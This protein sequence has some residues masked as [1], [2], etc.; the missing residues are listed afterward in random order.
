MEP[1]P[2]A[3]TTGGETPLRRTHPISP[4]IQVARS[5]PAFIFFV[6]FAVSRGASLPT[7]G[8]A[9]VV[10][11]VGVLAAGT[12]FLQWQRRVFWFDADGDLRV[13]SGVVRRNERRVQLSRLQGV[14]IVQPVLARLA[15]LAQVKVESAG[16]TGES[17]AVIEYLTL[18]DAEA[19]RNEVLARSAGVAADA[20]AAPEDVL[21]V[22]P[23]D[24][25]IK[26]LLLRGATFGLL[27]ATVF[28]VLIAV[29]TEGPG[30]LVLIL[31]TGGLPLFSVFTE[32]SR[33]F[34][35]TVAR[36]PDGLRLRYG[37]LQRQAHTVPPG[38]VQAIGFVEPWLWRRFGWVR[39][40]VVL[41]GGRAGDNQNAIANGV[42]L[43]VAPWPVARQLAAS[44][45]AGTDVAAHQWF[46]ADEK[47]RWSNPFQWRNLAVAYDADVFATRSGWLTRRTGF[48]PHVRTQ[49]VEVSQGPWQRYLGLATVDVHTVD[50]P[51]SIVGHGRPAAQARNLADAQAVRAEQARQGDRSTRWMSQPSPES[52]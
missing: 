10:L 25:L 7:V 28:L 34:D 20:P 41:A 23:T 2:A 51:V 52:T 27:L 38:R 8:L 47:A 42:L 48:V 29:L 24:L 17:T 19:L 32:F 50:G 30:G 49:S 5:A 36:S 12:A 46:P 22:V 4:I 3:R 13:D 43:P 16:S 44:L 26:S 14:E 18:S 11:V 31:I 6:F 40:Q 21:H 45:M 37:L 39:V 1:V 33:F 15:G 35:F 9:G